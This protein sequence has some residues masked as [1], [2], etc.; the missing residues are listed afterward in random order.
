MSGWRTQHNHF[1]KFHY[2]NLEAFPAATIKNYDNLFIWIVLTS[3]QNSEREKADKTFGFAFE[4]LM[5]ADGTT[6]CD[7]THDLCVY[8]VS[9][10]FI[11]T[12]VICSG[13]VLQLRLKYYEALIR[14]LRVW[15]D[16]LAT[17]NLTK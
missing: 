16:Y 8:K 14:F 17:N 15:F 10:T 3:F 9:L 12:S 2:T 13:T 11:V 4:S 7:S 5:R 1:P 6:I